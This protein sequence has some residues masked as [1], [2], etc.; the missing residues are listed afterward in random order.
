M[1]FDA[2]NPFARAGDRMGFI[3]KVYVIIMAQMAV[4]AS[5]I[6]TFMYTPSLQ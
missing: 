3:R 4:T 1:E 2:E 6:I 5:M